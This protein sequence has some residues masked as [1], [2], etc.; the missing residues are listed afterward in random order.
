MKT[1]IILLAAG[2]SSRLGQPKQLLLYE[3]Q[4]L[5]RRMALTAAE[6]QCG[7]VIVILGKDA[8]AC[9]VELR[10]LPV[11][12]AQNQE[13]AEGMVSSLRAGLAVLSE[14]EPE[15]E[16]V[17]IMVCDQPRVDGN[18]LR[19][20]VRQCQGNTSIVA[21][22][23]SDALGVPAVFAR[24]H[25]PELMELRGDHGAKI[26]LAQHADLVAAV[27]FPEGAIDIDAPEDLAVSE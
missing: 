24:R 10:D 11:R 14:V 17:L 21:S 15:A 3:G 1:G 22:G 7:R 19:A 25:F 26:L 12:I 16:A 9:A 13:W 18:L 27:P 4:T 6:S 23:Y 20:L 8:D 2:G 5:L